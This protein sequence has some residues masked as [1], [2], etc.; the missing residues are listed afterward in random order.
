MN[1]SKLKSIK[2]ILNMK[3]ILLSNKIKLESATEE[4]KTELKESIKTNINSIR[5]VLKECYKNNYID[6]ATNNKLS[7]SLYEYEQ[8]MTSDLFNSFCGSIKA[9]ILP[10][11]SAPSTETPLKLLK[12]QTLLNLVLS[13]FFS[14]TVCGLIYAPI[15]PVKSAP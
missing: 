10:V 3:Q 7:K 11:K 12:K 4:E 5:E 9:L 1:N 2:D 8:N 13:R 14:N 6:T 15:L